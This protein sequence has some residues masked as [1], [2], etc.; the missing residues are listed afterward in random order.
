MR[1]FFA[2]F[3]KVALYVSICLFC[4]SLLSDAF[5]CTASAP[6]SGFPGWQLFFFGWAAL[7]HGGVSWLANPA[8][9]AAWLLLASHRPVLSGGLAA[10]GL[11]LM[12]SFLLVSEVAS[13]YEDGIVRPAAY[14]AGYALWVASAIVSLLGSIVAAMPTNFLNEPATNAP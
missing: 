8:M 7:P 5:Y 10:L 12:L 3:P 9:A 6:R 4:I 1:S 13:M 2:V 11:T 14:G